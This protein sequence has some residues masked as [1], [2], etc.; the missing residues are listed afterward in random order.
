MVNISK[1]VLVTGGF[2]PIH[3]GHIN[4]LKKASELGDK[5]IVGVNSDDWLKRKKK[6]F[7]MTL[8]ERKTIIENLNMVDQVIVW[9]D[10]DDTA[11]GAIDSLLAKFPEN[12]MLIFANGGDRKKNNIPE[13]QRYTKNRRVVFKFGIGGYNK[14][15]SSS[16]ILEKFKD[17]FFKK[18]F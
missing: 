11:C 14:K 2:D 12:I 7:F 17:S 15:N 8:K 5:L 16:L 9:D 6:C 1:L 10:S 18:T 13:I 4:L 3:S